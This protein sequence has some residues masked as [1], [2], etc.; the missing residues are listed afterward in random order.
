MVD[1]RDERFPSKS[2][3][4]EDAGMVSHSG[5]DD[6]NWLPRRITKDVLIHL[7]A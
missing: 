3:R 1:L 6:G 7:R 5:D 4:T 2:A